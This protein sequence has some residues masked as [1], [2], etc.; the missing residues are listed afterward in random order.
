MY[1]SYLLLYFLVVIYILIF[2]KKID[3]F[4]LLFV[5]YSVYFFPFLFQKL[6]VLSNLGFF[7]QEFKDIHPDFLLSSIIFLTIFLISLIMYDIIF[8]KLR[9]AINMNIKLKSDLKIFKIVKYFTLFLFGVILFLTK[10]NLTL[11]KT[12]IQQIGG[13]YMTI[14]VYTFSL[15][16]LFSLYNKFKLNIKLD[17]IFFI[18]V[19]FTL[20][21]FKQRSIV[22]IPIIAFLFYFTWNEHISLK[23]IKNSFYIFSILLFILL[24]KVFGNILFLNIEFSFIDLILD[25]R[26]AF[27][28]F[29]IDATVN[30]LYYSHFTLDAAYL[31][32]APLFIFPG[33]N[34]LV[35]I[36]SG[37]FFNAYHS[38]VF[39]DVNFGMA[40][41]PIAEAFSTL[42][43]L[44][45]IIFSFSIIVSCIISNIFFNSTKGYLQILI[46][47]PSTYLFFYVFRNSLF[48][49]IV[50]IRI[51]ILFLIIIV[52]ISLIFK[53]KI[54][55]T[56]KTDVRNIRNK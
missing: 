29:I 2:R 27:E 28:P 5:G 52:L 45:V 37:Y 55:L 13:Y 7:T 38:V 41:S 51:F 31:L 42:G 17:Y 23:Y 56:R 9:L 48:T 39:P 4:F 11:S 6:P 10:I 33:L 16:I 21:Y 19:F 14:Y 43:F 30:E 26:D 49:E 12:E 25:L 50:Y 36:K 53:N 20:V 44:G 22:I 32:K 46:S 1:I 35:G 18:L 3:A 8:Y 34:H 54:I 24:S 15:Y 47:L 40:Y